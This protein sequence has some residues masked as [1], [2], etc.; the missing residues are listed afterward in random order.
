MIPLNKCKCTNGFPVY[1]VLTVRVVYEKLLPLLS[2]GK[3]KALTSDRVYEAFSG[4]NPLH[5]NPY[6]EVSPDIH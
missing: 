1:Q 3:Q 5:Y 6:T 2:G 4:I